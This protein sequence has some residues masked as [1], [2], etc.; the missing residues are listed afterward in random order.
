MKDAYEVLRH[1]EADIARI[2]HEIASLRVVAPLLSSEQPDKKPQ[3]S[4]EE[5]REND[6]DA[7]GTDGL[8][9]SISPSGA[10]IW[11]VLKR[12]K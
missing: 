2:R 4:A 10:K 5:A 6:A 1:K 8:F 7:T 9:S 12:G 3:T 11:G